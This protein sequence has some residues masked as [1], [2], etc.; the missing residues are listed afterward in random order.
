MIKAMCVRLIERNKGKEAINLEDFHEFDLEYDGIEEIANDL[1]TCAEAF[2]DDYFDSEDI[3]DVLRGGGSWV[4][5][6]DLATKKFY[7]LWVRA[8]CNVYYYFNKS[9]NKDGY[10]LEEKKNG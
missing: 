5:V 9:L 3:D 6:Y 2:C 8:E 10:I 7:I 4:G 1:M